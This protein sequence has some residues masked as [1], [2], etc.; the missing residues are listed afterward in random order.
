MVHRGTDL[1]RALSLAQRL[2]GPSYKSVVFRHR[3]SGRGG[4][5]YPQF[6]NKMAES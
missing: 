4:R 1:F 3:A 5:H 6:M 2:R